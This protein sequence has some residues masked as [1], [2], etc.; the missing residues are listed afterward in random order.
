MLFSCE[1]FYSIL[2]SCFYIGIST[3]RPMCISW[4]THAN[5][6]KHPQTPTFIWGRRESAGFYNA[7]LLSSG[8]QRN[9]GWTSLSF[10]RFKLNFLKRIMTGHSEN[11]KWHSY[12]IIMQLNS[13]ALKNFRIINM[14]PEAYL[15]IINTRPKFRA[16]IWIKKGLS[17]GFELHKPGSSGF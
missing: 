12:V 3:I 5:T 13:Y 11:D 8:G 2:V 6:H 7:N 15:L 14:K 17:R 4:Y 16:A 1:P 10:T 9:I